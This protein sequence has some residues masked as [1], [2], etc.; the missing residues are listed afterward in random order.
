MRVMSG[1]K[2][3]P[4]R[5]IELHAVS[6]VAPG[7]FPKG[8]MVPSDQRDDQPCLTVPHA[9]SLVAHRPARPCQRRR[10]CP[11][12]WQPLRRAP[13]PV[14]H[15]SHR[16][17]TNHLRS[18]LRSFPPSSLPPPLLRSS[19]PILSSPLSLSIS[20]TSHLLFA[21]HS[22]RSFP[23]SP[24]LLNLSSSPL[25]FA[26]RS[27]LSSSPLLFALISSPSSLRFPLRSSPVLAPVLVL[28]LRTCR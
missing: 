4:S 23:L 27:P 21:L 20:H 19:L 9:V 26:L 11:A 5:L 16:L 3:D 7:W 15:T 13:P 1:W 6:L 24:S 10:S 17:F 22:H 28:T 8:G 18:P 12:T 2:D 25:L 14:S